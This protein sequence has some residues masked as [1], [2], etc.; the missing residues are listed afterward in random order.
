MK[1]A[2]NLLKAVLHKKRYA[3]RSTAGAWVSVADSP[4]LDIIDDL[5]VEF[6][7][8]PKVGVT[9]YA[10]QFAYKGT[11][12]SA[13]SQFACYFFGTTSGEDKVLRFYGSPGGAWQAI[14]PSLVLALDALYHVVFRWNSVT[15]GTLHVNAVSQGAAVGAGAGTLPINADEL[16]LALSGGGSDIVLDGVRIYSRRLSDAE[17]TDHYRGAFANET[18]LV[19]YW[20]FDDGA[21]TV[22]T[23]LSGY[24]NHGTLVGGPTWVENYLCPGDER[25]FIMT[26]LYTFSLVGGTTVRYTSADV[27]IKIGA[28]VYSAAG[29]KFQRSRIREV[30]GVE[31]D[32]LSLDLAADTSH[33]VSGVPWLKAIKSGLLDGATMKLERAFL[34]DWRYAP[35]GVL[36]RFAGRVAPSSAGRTKGQIQ[37]KSYL[38]LLSHQ[39]P[40]NLFQP[41]CRNTLFDAGCTLKKWNFFNLSSVGGGSSR[42]SINTGLAQAAG[43]YDLGTIDFVAAASLPGTSNNTVSSPDSVAASIAGDIDL[44][45]KLAAVDWT[46]ASIIYPFHKYSGAPNGSWVF[47]LQGGSTG[48][49][50]FEWVD[51]GGTL[52]S[53]AST[54][55]PVVTDG[56]PLWLRVTLDVNNGAGGHVVTYYTSIDGVTWNQLGATVNAGAFT[57]SI[58]DD[59]DPLLLGNLWAGV[60][61]YAEIRNGID[62]P[63]VAKFDPTRDE[64]PTPLTVKASTGEMWT[65]NTSGGTPAALIGTVNRGVTRSIKKHT[66]GVLGLAL[67][68][69]NAPV[70]GD[71]FFAFPGCDKLQATCTTKFSNL[72]NF[73]AEPY[74]PIP[75]TVL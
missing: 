67:P 31:V 12:G 45:I 52:R 20:D 27:D 9:G 34:T 47:G 36:T 2:S 55:A 16:I 22:A 44:R 60:V 70:T 68:L 64:L 32:T 19:G 38:E 50:V 17:V 28:N 63:I 25:R 54:A 41:G 74:T 75:E 40:R 33:L 5:T 61:Y 26:D 43:F 1:A 6:W 15:G 42:T 72:P 7:V 11:P 4:A 65:V 51:S 18:G 71:P 46:P 56:Q 58:K 69:P 8:K 49:P 73:R 10:T 3:V 13:S 48:R 37:V 39:W 21:G 66:S 53:T 24:G 14:S 59:V 23:D 57:T 62:G 29:P 30:L 35:A